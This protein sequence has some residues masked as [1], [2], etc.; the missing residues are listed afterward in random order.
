MYPGADGKIR[1]AESEYGKDPADGYWK[2]RPPGQH[3]G[4]FSLHDVTEHEDAT[5]TVSP[6]ILVTGY[7]NDC[8]VEWHGYLEH[9]VW[10]QV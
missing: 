8:K 1:F 10:R 6:S 5:I 7:Q 3:L 2:G 9:G 4:D